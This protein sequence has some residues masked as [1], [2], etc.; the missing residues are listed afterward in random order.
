MGRKGEDT[1]RTP[2]AILFDPWVDRR[3]TPASGSLAKGKRPARALLRRASPRL[4]LLA[5][6]LARQRQIVL[7]SPMAL[8]HLPVPNMS[9]SA[10][11]T[12]PPQAISIARYSGEST[13]SASA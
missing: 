6:I 3:E 12:S 13:S 10:A 11:R 8:L 9:R 5:A 4:F 2:N 7:A 1:S